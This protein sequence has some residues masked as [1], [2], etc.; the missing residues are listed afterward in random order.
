MADVTYRTRDEDVYDGSTGGKIDTHTYHEIGVTLDGVF[1]P[2]LSK[3]GGYVDALVERG[4]AAQEAEQH[5]PS[6]TTMAPTGS[7]TA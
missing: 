5:T 6:S 3:A 4:K 1:V 2:F 7:E